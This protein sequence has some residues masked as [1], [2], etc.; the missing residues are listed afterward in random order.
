MVLADEQ[1]R[2][3]RPA[4]TTTRAN[5]AVINPTTGAIVGGPRY[6]GIVLPGD[7][8]PGDGER[9]GGRTTIRRCWRCSRARRAGF[10]ETHKNVFEPRVGVSYALNDKTI[11][12]AS[13]GV[14][15]NRVTLNDSLLLGGNPPFQPQVSVSNGI[16]RQPGRRRRR[17]RAAVRHDRAATRCSS[18][19]TAYM[20][21]AGVQRE[22]PL[23]FVVDATYVG[24]AGTYLQRER[25]INQLRA[26]H[27]PGEPGRQHRGAAAVP[28]LRRHPSVGERRPLDVQQ[29]A[30]QRRPPLHATA[31]SSAPPIRSA[32]PRTTRATSANVLFN[33]YDDSGYWGPS[34]FDRRHVFNF[35][36]IYDLPFFQRA[37]HAARERAGRLADLGRDVHAHGHAVLGHARRRHRRRRRRASRQPWNQVG[38]PIDGANRQFSAGTA[39][40]ELLVQSG[41]VR[42]RR[43][44]AR[45]ATRRATRSTTRA[46]IS[47]TS[48][49]SRTSRCSGTQSVQ[50]RA[51]I[52]NF[53]NHPNWNGAAGRP[54][55]LDVRTRHEQGQLASRH[56]VE[57]EVPV[58][59]LFGTS[60]SGFGFGVRSSQV[61]ERPN[62]LPTPRTR[63]TN[64]EPEPDHEPRTTNPEP[65]RIHQCKSSAPAR[66]TT[67]PSSAPA[68]AAAWPPRSS[69][70]RAPTSSC[71][72]RA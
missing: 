26:G 34:S 72:R 59:S 51:E 33:T 35:Y 50:F 5:Q 18:I 12:K 52:F 63:T 8:F 13:A 54:D 27:G 3:L 14:F 29:P 22:V 49:S 9:P 37:E 40:S 62:Q 17:G 7:G 66:S 6:N 38:D 28:G 53:L 68:P 19:P 45:S 4:R 57:S 39:R 23:G 10:S 41:G 70:K 15:H 69:P 31:S 61:R 48:R 42:A 11:F 56:S 60:G 25:N 44:P 36:Y 2:E 65:A 21:S 67:W 20:W 43:R 24:R 16:G 71:S 30:D 55:Q 1:H 32:S 46:S 64:S 47:G 58:L